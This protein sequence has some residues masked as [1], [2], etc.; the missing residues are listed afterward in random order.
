M[1]DQT[2][3]HGFT[4]FNL[5]CALAMAEIGEHAGAAE[6]EWW[7]VAD[8]DSAGL[9]TVFAKA[10]RIFGRWNAR[11]VPRNCWTRSSRWR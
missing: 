5:E 2:A 6:G 11:E 4:H 8:I 3:E 10:A 1:L 7:P 9:P